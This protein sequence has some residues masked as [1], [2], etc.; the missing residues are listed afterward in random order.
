M[1]GQKAKLVTQR[2]GDEAAR[3]LAGYE[4]T[5]GYVIVRKALAAKPES[6][7]QVEKAS[8]VTVAK[9]AKK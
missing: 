3:T 2:F 6:K 9:K 5:G 7:P 8:K 4:K 1:A